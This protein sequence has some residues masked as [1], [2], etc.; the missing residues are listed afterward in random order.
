MESPSSI[1]NIIPTH[2]RQDILWP[3]MGPPTLALVGQTNSVLHQEVSHAFTNEKVDQWTHILGQGKTLMTA[4]M[5]EALALVEDPHFS[6]SVRYTDAPFR[7]MGDFMSEIYV[8][9]VLRVKGT[10]SLPL[11]LQKPV[12]CVLSFF[13]NDDA[14]VWRVFFT[15]HQIVED[16]GNAQH[17]E[18][19]TLTIHCSVRRG[20]Q[21]MFA[22]T[23]RA[24]AGPQWWEVSWLRK[25][26][27]H[28]I[29]S[30][31]VHHVQYEDAI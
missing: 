6:I 15:S 22:K 19:Y 16:K 30:E 29:F 13:S 5:K 23:W 8:N 4:A 18:S 2:L 27:L 21:E 28:P 17:H 9:D 31:H 12:E 25:Y 20:D 14:P 10:L 24:H 3:E 11:D 1:L 26:I 7:F